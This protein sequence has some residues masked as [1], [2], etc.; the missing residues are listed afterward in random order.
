MFERPLLLVVVVQ[1]AKLECTSPLCCCS[2]SSA[3]RRSASVCVTESPQPHNYSSTKGYSTKDLLFLSSLVV[4]Y[5]T[6]KTN[7]IYFLLLFESFFWVV[8][9]QCSLFRSVFSQRGAMCLCYFDLWDEMR[10]IIFMSSLFYV[11]KLDSD[12]FHSSKHPVPIS[13]NRPIRR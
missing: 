5:Y 4:Q 11:V 9:V 13:N 1:T 6:V 8:V 7:F 3:V 2:S 12:R 10:D